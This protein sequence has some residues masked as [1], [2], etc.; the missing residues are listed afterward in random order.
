[1]SGR[2][3]LAAVASVLASAVT[4]ALLITLTARG[5]DIGFFFF[6]LLFALV[7]AFGH[8]VFLAFPLYLQLLDRWPLRWWNAGLAGLLI[9]AMPTLLLGLVLRLDLEPL[10]S[11]VACC[12]ASG[13]VGGLVFCLVRGEDVVVQEG[14]A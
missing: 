6:C 13:L 8:A 11:G 7:V 2:G 1:M 4:G 10:L 5:A 3:P 12:G 14:G 9:G